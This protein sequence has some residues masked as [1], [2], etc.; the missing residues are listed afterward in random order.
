MSANNTK[1]IRKKGLKISD[2]INPIVIA[3][4]ET[5]SNEGGIGFSRKLLPFRS[6]FA[7]IEERERETSSANQ[8]YQKYITHEFI[9]RTYPGEFISPQEDVI[10]HQ[11]QIYDIK[12]VQRLRD[13][14]PYIR[15][16]T[17]LED[18]VSNYE[19]I[20]EKIASPTSTE[21]DEVQFPEF[22]KWR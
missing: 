14:V 6:C 16:I 5:T 19:Y 11:E 1:N 9:I 8:D 7:K 15:I 12:L 18:K 3:K 10:L 22:G 20:S 2:L 4:K 21:D 13:G 17:T